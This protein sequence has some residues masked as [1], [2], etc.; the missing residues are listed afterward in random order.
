MSFYN[1]FVLIVKAY[2]EGI[3]SPDEILFSLFNTFVKYK[4]T[5]YLSLFRK[6]TKDD[7]LDL[8]KS[9]ITYKE[10]MTD[11]SYVNYVIAQLNIAKLDFSKCDELIDLLGAYF[12]L[13]E[14]YRKDLGW[15]L[16]N[17]LHFL[18]VWNKDISDWIEKAILNLNSGD[19]KRAALNF[20]NQ[21]PWIPKEM[22]AKVFEKFSL[23]RDKEGLAL[24]NGSPLFQ[25]VTLWGDKEVCVDNILEFI[26]RKGNKK[27]EEDAYHQEFEKVI[28]AFKDVI[29]DKKRIIV[30]N[31]LFSLFVDNRISDST[32]KTI[33]LELREWLTPHLHSHVISLIKAHDDSPKQWLLLRIFAD[34]IPV[35]LQ[36]IYFNKVFDVVRDENDIHSI[37]AYKALPCMMQY[38]PA[39]Q[40][41]N[42]LTTLLQMITKISDELDNIKKK[43]YLLAALSSVKQKLS[44]EEQLILTK[45][46]LY[47]INQCLKLSS[48]QPRIKRKIKKYIQYLISLLSVFKKQIAES[49]LLNVRDALL[50][51]ICNTNHLA[52]WCTA[53]AASTLYVLHDRFPK[54]KQPQITANDILAIFVHLPIVTIGELRGKGIRIFIQKIMLLKAFM[55]PS[56][57]QLLLSKLLENPKLLNNFTFAFF[58]LLA[59]LKEAVRP[60]DEKK[61]IQLITMS[62][63]QNGSAFF[64][65]LAYHSLIKDDNLK[66]E[67]LNKL[68]RALTGH[69]FNAE[70]ARE[71]AW[72]LQDWCPDNFKQEFMFK[73]ICYTLSDA[74]TMSAKQIALQY[75]Q[76]NIDI[77]RAPYEL[78]CLLSKIAKN[79]SDVHLKIYFNHF[80]RIYKDKI[81][82]ALLAK[83]ANKT[84]AVLPNDIM[85]DIAKHVLSI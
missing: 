32:F 23:V 2:E 27:T 64:G 84:H 58:Y 19:D 82:L 76:D 63:S 24:M 78:I 40:Q 12:S 28:I 46:I 38:L 6:K 60:K 18:D 52:D 25:W 51:I 30:I 21:L 35:K 47:E 79:E 1:Y 10:T 55:A 15:R 4:N 62:M 57:L 14:I 56:E 20:I 41:K 44:I 17:Q 33:M 54:E 7:H 81:G 39:E 75:L 22:R 59:E 34:I 83:A 71:V 16:I 74:E 70:H 77:T 11:Q 61:I 85:N 43:R 26:A 69:L 37:S 67:L 31:Q 66:K 45:A 50:Q 36:K 9:L 49:E 13:Y 53:E 48:K 80:Y 73:L 68:L 5:G 3:S 72:Q 8:V 65:L 42:I 29:P